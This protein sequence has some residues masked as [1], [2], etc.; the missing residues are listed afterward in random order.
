[1]PK[2]TIIVDG[3]SNKGNVKAKYEQKNP[4]KVV[5]KVK[6]FKPFSIG[7]SGVNSARKAEVTFKIKKDR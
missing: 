2:E 3:K 5:T 1:M 6:L 7:F 4:L